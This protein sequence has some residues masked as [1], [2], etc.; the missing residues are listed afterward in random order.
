MQIKVKNSKTHK[1]Y[2]DLD[3]KSVM[4]ET[5]VAEAKLVLIPLALPKT[6]HEVCIKGNYYKP[7]L[8]S[9]TE[10]IED[11]GRE[12]FYD[13]IN[14]SIQKADIFM[15][16]LEEQLS[17]GLYKT[18]A[19]PEHFSPK[20]LQAIVDGMLKDG[21]KVLVECEEHR[22]FEGAKKGFGYFKAIKLN[23]SHHITI[24]K[25]EKKM[26]TKEEAIEL[27]AKRQYQETENDLKMKEC[28]N[29]SR[30]WFEQNIKK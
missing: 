11:N 14:S 30:E 6:I 27:L 21:D 4:A 3:S 15:M 12:W 19:L 5:I 13:S 23:S 18:L 7:L 24:H 28:I 9:E 2:S 1:I 17:R 29:M 16:S 20:H 8:V 26:Y 25:I 22:P 10:K